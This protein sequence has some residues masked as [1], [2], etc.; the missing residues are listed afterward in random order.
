MIFEP[1]AMANHHVGAQLFRVPIFRGGKSICC[2]A[3]TV[4]V[5]TRRTL[6]RL[7]YHEQRIADEFSCLRQV[8]S[9][10]ILH[11]WFL[12]SEHCLAL[13]QREQAVTVSKNI[14]WWKVNSTEMDTLPWQ[15]IWE[16][17]RVNLMLI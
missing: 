16:E 15:M 13:A 5:G 14:A 3:T 17:L 2:L 11:N 8:I 10:H 6:E 4:W 1:N 7:L 9:K 12:E